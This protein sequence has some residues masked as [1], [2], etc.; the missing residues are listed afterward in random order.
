MSQVSKTTMKPSSPKTHHDTWK[1]CQR[2][3]CRVEIEK[4]EVGTTETNVN[5]RAEYESRSHTSANYEWLFF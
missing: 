5:G 4:A 2:R 1:E 3:T